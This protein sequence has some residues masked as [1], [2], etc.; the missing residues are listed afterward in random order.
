MAT[1]EVPN[2]HPPPP[3]NINNNN[4]RKEDEADPTQEGRHHY[5]MLTRRDEGRLRTAFWGQWAHHRKRRLAWNQQQQ[6]QQTNSNRTDSPNQQQPKTLQERV[7]WRLVRNTAA[8]SGSQVGTLPLSNCHTIMWTGD[9]QLG[10]PPQ[11][12]AVDIDT[13]SSDLW[14]PS[15]KCDASCLEYPPDW[16]TYN[17]T[18]SSTYRVASDNAA[19]NAFSSEYVDGESMTGEH[20]IDVLQLGP[21]V[22]IQDQVFAQVTSFGEYTSCSGEEGL[23]GLAFSEISSHKFPTTISNLKSVLTHPIF[24]MYLDRTVD[25]YPGSL[26][27]H[28]HDEHESTT[29]KTAAHATSANSGL[30][31]GSVDSQ[32]YTGCLSWHEL[33][34][35][36]ELSG[37]T[38]RGYWDFKLDQVLFQG[39]EIPH[40]SLALVDSGSSFLLGPTD[41]VGRVA[42]LAGVDC[43]AMDEYDMP[44]FVDC[45]DAGNWDTAAYDCDM[46]L[47]DLHF[48]A[49]GVHHVLTQDD[50]T[51][52]LETEAGEI[53]VLR[54]VGDFELPG[55]SKYRV[56][57]VILVCGGGRAVWNE[58]T[59]GVDSM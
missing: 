11:T 38:F 16:R 31:L 54:I 14:V 35:F 6:Q 33:G 32:K 17:E 24:S 28:Q 51:D 59:V 45:A 21:S 1:P 47:G 13:G 42:A 48:V 40:S 18:A 15:T 41:A 3:S 4:N 34:Q 39:E 44:N 43:I 5:H 27:D 46:D 56:L 36:K 37:A 58:E 8:T 12:F 53:C 20:A 19:L 22:R 26:L 29:P 30:L 9:I 50:L 2:E 57:V 55:W 10:T 49:D 7:Q 52:R 23:L 25:D